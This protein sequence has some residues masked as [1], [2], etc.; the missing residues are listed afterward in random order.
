MGL[1]FSVNPVNVFHNPEQNY[2]VAVE[3]QTLGAFGGSEFMFGLRAGTL[4]NATVSSPIA[5]PTGTT[6][7]TVVGTNAAGCNDTA[8]VTVTVILLL[9]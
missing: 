2:F 4:S 6:T 3:Q 7:Y 9:Q 5:S 8:F 1:G